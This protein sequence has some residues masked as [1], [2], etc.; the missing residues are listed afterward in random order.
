[1]YPDIRTLPSPHVASLGSDLLNSLLVFTK[2]TNDQ[3][4]AVF[5]AICATLVLNGCA[6]HS[7]PAD[8]VAYKKEIEQ[9]RAA[10]LA[11]LTNESGWLTLIGLFWL[12]EG[13]NKLG[14]DPVNEI[15]LPKAKLPAQAAAFVLTNGA[16][17][18]ETPLANTFF[19]EADQSHRC[20]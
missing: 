15:I 1:M 6:N 10:R 11:E 18:F 9:W 14:S 7:N 13:T 17:R 2:K 19:V 16:V 8:A 3:I 5:F 20:N 4:G 12:K